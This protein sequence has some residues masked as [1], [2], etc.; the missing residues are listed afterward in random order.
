MLKKLRFTA[1]LTALALILSTGCTGVGPRTVTR[2]R[3]DYVNAITGSWKKQMLL[4]IVKVRYLDAPV[5]LEVA[6][7]ISQYAVEGQ[8]NMGATLGDNIVGDGIT[9]G[10]SGKYTDRP[11]ITYMPLTGEKFARSLM[12]PIPTRAI[13]SMIQSEFPVDFLFKILVQTINGID[14]RFGGT[15]M[16]RPADPRFYQVIELLGR[17]QQS[18]GLGMRFKPLGKKEPVVIFFRGQPTEEI[19]NETNTVRQLLGLKKDAREFRVVHGAIAADDQEI[20]I[21]TRSMIQIMTELAS[22]VDV[23][24]KDIAEG[25]VQAPSKETMSEYPALIRVRNTGERPEDAYVAVPYRSQWFWI[26]DRDLTSKRVFSFLMLFFS[27]T[28]KGDRQGAPIVTVPTN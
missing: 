8:I 5:F 14:N 1:I 22:Y 20:A 6:S 3:F 10:G 9:V 4:N 27:L 15:L 25:R 19:R 13:L 18:G 11:T 12:T 23:P 17:I 16:E 7:V 28:E 21:I 2:D 24:E 26:D